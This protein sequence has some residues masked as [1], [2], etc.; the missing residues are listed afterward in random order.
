MQEK[1]L[2]NNTDSI[3]KVIEG[4]NKAAKII[5]S[6]MGGSG[7]NVLMFEDGKLVF[8]KDGV[9]VARK[10]QFLDVEHDA[11]AQMLITAANKTVKE[12]G[13]GTTLT[14]LFVRE[15]VNIIF[16]AC[17]NTNDVNAVLD[18]F[19]SEVN[20]LIEILQNRT[21]KISNI[22]DIYDIALTSCKDQSIA[23]LIYEIYRKVG[24]KASITAQLT[25]SSKS[26]H[27]ITKGLNFDVGLINPGFANQ[28][29]GTFSA[30]QV[31]VWVIKDVVSDFQ[32]YGPMINDLHKKKTPLL[33]IAKDFSDSFIRLCLT[34]KENIGLNICLVKQPGWGEGVIE[35]IKDINAFITGST[36][37]KVV[38]SSTD[39][40]LYNNPDLRKIRKR[41]AQLQAKIEAATEEF[42]VRDYQ[43][44]IDNLNQTTA[45]IFV[46][47]KTLANAKEE[48]DRIEDAIGA[49]KT[50]VKHGF[51][52][53]SGSELVDIADYSGFL[54]SEEFRNILYAPARQIL[55]NANILVE[56]V[57]TPYNVKTKTLDPKL[58]DP[59]NILIVA[60]LNGFA[61]AKLLV[62]T[63][64]VLYD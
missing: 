17:Q 51:V 36:V 63:S 7:K 14:S 20:S 40:T 32:Y 49:C 26:Y 64:F 12:C 8:T 38:V 55:N 50:A 29:N 60:L 21:S 44:R 25:E 34:N 28:A 23:S 39:F 15:F 2:P 33:I 24:I 45:I 56:P 35:N 57:S 48:F 37:N 9:S 10:I 4:I 3:E 22:S 1:K 43:R 41:V 11:G 19:E 53:G 62:N 52:R 13:D 27:E 5:T 54:W 61:L 6:T 16:K 18:S 30:E 59:T 47:G 31:E 58:K 46:G 42:D